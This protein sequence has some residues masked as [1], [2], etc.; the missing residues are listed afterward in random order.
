[1]DTWEWL[2]NE[3]SLVPTGGYIHIALEQDTWVYVHNGLR[4]LLSNFTQVVQT[5]KVLPYGIF[6]I[7]TATGKL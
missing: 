6:F 5:G 4:E 7:I 3:I 2:K 1:M